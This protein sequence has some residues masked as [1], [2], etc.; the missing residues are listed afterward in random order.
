M[1]RGIDGDNVANVGVP[2]NV[3]VVDISAIVNDTEM[4]KSE[5][6]TAECRKPERMVI[7]NI[8]GIGAHLQTQVILRR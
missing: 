3:A 5:Q 4:R 6:N 1:I 7:I 2:E 8:I